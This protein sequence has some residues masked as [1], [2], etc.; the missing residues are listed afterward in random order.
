MRSRLLGDG[1]LVLPAALFVVTTIYLYEAFQ[2]HPQYD[3]GFVGPRFLPIVVSIVMYAGLGFLVFDILRS[4][5]PRPER[6][7]PE[8]RNFLP[9]IAVVIATLV[10]IAVFETLG[11]VVSTLLY[12]FALL[13]VFKFDQNVVWRAI[14]AIIITAVF[15]ILFHTL[16]DVRLPTLTEW[17]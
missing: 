12:V 5:E 9:A 4:G 13:F 8:I 2:I 6:A 17:F 11:Y 15:Y 1:R 7:R 3:E 14:Y 16:F 10:Y